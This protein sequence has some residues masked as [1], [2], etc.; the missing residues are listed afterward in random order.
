MAMSDVARSAAHGAQRDSTSTSR[1]A[2]PTQR[3]SPTAQHDIKN[4]IN[5]PGPS[6]RPTREAGEQAT[7]PLRAAEFRR[8]LSSDTMSTSQAPS[9]ASEVGGTSP[10]QTR[11]G[12]SAS[13]AP[14]TASASSQGHVGQV[15]SNCG[16]TQT[17]LWRR[18][19]QGTTICNACG[20]YQKARNASRPTSLKKKPPQLVS[21]NSRAAPT[22]IAPAPGPG[23]KYPGGP[24]PTYVTE[25]QVPTGTCPGGGKCNGTGGA[26][27]CGGCPAYNN[28][29]SKSAQ[30]N[31]QQQGQ[32]CGSAGQQ[33]DQGVDDP[34]APIDIAALQIQNQN[35]TVVI[36][37]QNCGTTTT[38]LW[39]RDESGHTI[40]NACGLY[41]KLHG[42]HRPVS[43]KKSII[44]RR[45]RV[46]PNAYAGSDWNE[47]YDGSETQSQAPEGS[48]ERGSMNDDGSINLGLRLR[49]HGLPPILPSAPSSSSQHNTTLPP[50]ADLAGYQPPTHQRPSLPSNDSHS[51]EN[52]LAP[53]TS[54][55]HVADR[56]AS[57]S[58]ASFV[59]PS[60]KR[61]F[62]AADNDSL[63]TPD[64]GPE[65]S[66]RLSSIK[67]ILNPSNMAQSQSEEAGEMYSRATRVSP[68][69]APSPGSY[70][71]TGGTSSPTASGYP[72]SQPV[73]DDGGRRM[74]LEQ[75]AHRMREAL[76]AKERE[77]ASLSR[78]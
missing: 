50:V 70:S 47:E 41:Y 40:C 33:G 62:S 21:A 43:M 73:Q 37:C 29:V 78:P 1:T 6:A 3:K 18:S 11:T 38:P 13:P 53:I 12:V 68:G 54:M 17:P 58:P 57:M 51:Y 34:S 77:L 46:M 19:P 52:R 25:E 64:G 65:S 48:P 75:E 56:Q 32:G 2:L 5:G 74:A 36:A 67:S 71:N 72:P 49:P 42:V 31:P 63:P 9:P 14:T 44:K 15:C 55:T 30:L 16:T 23:P 8:S 35:T 26:E 20:L 39:R 76:A 7:I 66:K 22:K 4:T 10:T 24:A 69:F 45:K 59:S 28:R 27:G 61:S 60:R